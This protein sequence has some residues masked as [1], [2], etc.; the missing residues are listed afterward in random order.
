M[1]ELVLSSLESAA[2]SQLAW[3]LVVQSNAIPS[4]THLGNTCRGWCWHVRRLQHW[5][6]RQVVMSDFSKFP[7]SSRLSVL[8][9]HDR[10]RHHQWNRAD[11]VTAREQHHPGV[12]HSGDEIWLLARLQVWSSTR[13]C[14]WSRRRV[15]CA[16]EGAS[17]SCEPVLLF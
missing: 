4:R 7:G 14:S 10:R 8:W 15:V 12:T 17:L 1:H 5:R 9:T 3:M 2:F 13:V 6:F 16:G 11:E